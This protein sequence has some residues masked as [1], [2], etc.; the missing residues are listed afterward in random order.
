LLSNFG[1]IEKNYEKQP[2]FAHFGIFQ[3]LP[4]DQNLQKNEVL[5]IIFY[6]FSILSGLFLIK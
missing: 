1:K 4:T 5:G 3:N 2:K 6:A